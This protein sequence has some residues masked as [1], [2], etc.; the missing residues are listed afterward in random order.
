MIGLM[1][2]LFVSTKPQSAAPVEVATVA[3]EVAVVAVGMVV[4]VAE[5]I[6]AEEED[7]VSHIIYRLTDPADTYRWRWR[8]I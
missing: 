3:E 6:V 5:A 4:D 8:R 7:M 2:V 1:V